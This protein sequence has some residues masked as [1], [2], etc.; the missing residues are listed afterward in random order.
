MVYIGDQHYHG[1]SSPILTFWLFDPGLTTRL[2]YGYP[3]RV[4]EMEVCYSD[5]W[6]IKSLGISDR[7]R[8]DKI[9]PL[10]GAGR[11]AESIL[12]VTEASA[13]GGSDDIVAV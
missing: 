5:V 6:C 10:C 12:H 3:L 9:M 7:M 2:Y 11:S 1:I 8:D 4:A 13:A